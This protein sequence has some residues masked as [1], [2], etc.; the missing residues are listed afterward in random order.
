MSAQ[1]SPTSAG[2][3]LRELRQR[4]RMSQM[5]LAMRVGLS[6]RHL[7]CLETGKAS[8]SREMLVALLDGLDA[9]FEERNEA[10]VAAGYAPLHLHRPLHHSDMSLV[11]QVIETMIS[12]HES[13][14][15]VV[16]DNQWN[17]IKCNKGFIALVKGLGFDASVFQG[18][19]NFLT[20]M[21]A[22]GGLSDYLINRDEVMAEVIKRAKR[23]AAHNPKLREILGDHGQLDFRP[24]TQA[25]SLPALVTRIRSGLG[26]LRFI[27]TFTTFGSPLDITTA[28]LKIEHLFP[29]DEATK[30]AMKAWLE[31]VA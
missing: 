25:Q 29:G 31:E 26:E 30:L 10:M 16:L 17:L 22:P 24:Y 12:A 3:W 28:S 1:I 8:P 15:A 27:S 13:T 2:H 11:N 5:D 20:L 23:E 21:M 14:P 19:V 6:Q 18:P 4:Q 9:P 7:S